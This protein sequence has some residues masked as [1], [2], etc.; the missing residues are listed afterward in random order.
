MRPSYYPTS[1]PSVS[2]ETQWLTKRDQLLTQPWIDAANSLVYSD[3]RVDDRMIGG[4][5]TSWNQ[6]LSA[7]TISSITRKAISVQVVSVTSLLDVLNT[8]RSTSCVSKASVATIVTGLVSAF[9]GSSAAP[10]STICASTSSSTHRWMLGSCGVNA[11]PALCV[12]CATQL[13]PTAI[14]LSPCGQGTPGGCFLSGQSYPEPTDEIRLAVVTFSQRQPAPLIRRIAVNPTMKSVAVTVALDSEGYVYCSALTQPPV[15]TQAVFTANNVGRNHTVIPLASLVPATQ[16]KVYCLTVSAD[17]VQS[18]LQAMLDSSVAVRTGCCKSVMATTAM[19]SAQVNQAQANAIQLSLDGAPSN[20][21]TIA[22]KAVSNGVI[23]YSFFPTEINFIAKSA[24]LSTSVALTGIATPGTYIINVTISGPSAIEF[25]LANQQVMSFQVIAPN[26]EPPL[27]ELIQAQFSDDSSS[28]VISFD[29]ATNLGGSSF[30]STAF[31]CSALFQFQGDATSSCQWSQDAT[32]VTVSPGSTSH[33]NIGSQIAISPGIVK[34]AC[35]PALDCSKWKTM[36]KSVVQLLAPSNPT[37]PNV[38]ISTPA[39]IGACD[40]LVLDLSGSHGSGGRPWDS[41]T[42][43]VSSSAPNVTTLEEY[44]ND[45][46]RFSPPTA[47]G[48]Q[49]FQKSFSYTFTVTMCNF[50][51]YCSQNM[52]TVVILN[53]IVPTITIIGPQVLTQ[54]RSTPLAVVTNAFTANCDGS[55][56]TQFLQY[57]WSLTAPTAIQQ[58]AMSSSSRDPSKYLLP[59]FSLKTSIMYTLTATVTNAASKKSASTS[60]QVFVQPSILVAVISGGA[61][62]SARLNSQL[63]LDASGS[64]DQDQVSNGNVGLTYSWTCSQSS[65]VYSSSCSFSFPA[66]AWTRQ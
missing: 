60:V 20:A 43:S 57:S 52:A 14:F 27:P 30:G 18:Q 13:S 8:N 59:P 58:P 45:H 36:P 22:I 17:G 6:F 5:C 65:P 26:V 37:L 62:Q 12:G 64:Y 2:P 56:S 49:L 41:I 10:Q 4:G 25:S 42:F 16:Y 29:S 32:T 55:T 19:K 44:L 39:S 28:I 63:S 9:D 34:A 11:P 48:H 3:V 47:I 61:S 15:S 23:S 66:A 53:L 54:S 50:L 38:V 33:L 21:V 1:R 40:S 46:Y 51:S 35:K 31:V 7:L 24:L